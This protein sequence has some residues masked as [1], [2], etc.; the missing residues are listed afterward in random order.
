MCFKT[1]YGD[2]V[3]SPDATLYIKVPQRGSDED[4]RINRRESFEAE[5]EE[6]PET[7]QSCLKDVINGQKE[8]RLRRE[9]H[10]MAIL[11]EQ[12]KNL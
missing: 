6:E 11:G 12:G 9:N 8:E 2:L 10:L 7:L 4:M 3:D 5:G 1:A